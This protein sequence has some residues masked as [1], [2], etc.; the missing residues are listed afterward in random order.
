M[1]KPEMRTFGDVVDIVVAAIFVLGLNK[2]VSCCEAGR[3]LFEKMLWEKD[4]TSRSRKG[5]L[6]VIAYCVGT[7]KSPWLVPYSE[8]FGLYYRPASLQSFAFV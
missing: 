6:L 7:Y 3:K 1:P 5:I 8:P 4:T 2:S